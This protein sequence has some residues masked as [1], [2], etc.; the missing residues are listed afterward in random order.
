MSKIL[1]MLKWILAFGMISWIC[2]LFA[3]GSRGDDR[4]MISYFLSENWYVH[5]FVL[6]LLANQQEHLIY[7]DL[8]S[9]FCFLFIFVVK[10]YHNHNCSNCIVVQSLHGYGFNDNMEGIPPYFVRRWAPKVKATL[11]P[12][13][14]FNSITSQ[15]ASISQMIFKIQWFSWRLNLDFLLLSYYPNRR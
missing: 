2:I 15:R 14:T 9:T 5:S 12:V 11:K 8:F 13:Q 1:Q 10:S 4:M 6:L 3:E 7:Y